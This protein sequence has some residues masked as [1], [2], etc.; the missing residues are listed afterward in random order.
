MAK[1]ADVD[2]MLVGTDLTETSVGYAVSLVSDPQIFTLVVS[3]SS[4]HEARQLMG[5][6]AA[7]NTP[8]AA[9]VNVITSPTYKR[10]EWML[11]GPTGKAIWSE[12]A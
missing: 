9:Q 7:H 4:F 11:S 2:A 5:R 3:E 1:P 12:G 6:L 10:D 8:F